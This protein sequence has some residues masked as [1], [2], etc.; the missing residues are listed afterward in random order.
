LKNIYTSCYN[1]KIFCGYIIYSRLTV[2]TLDHNVNTVLS[3]NNKKSNNELNIVEN[4]LKL[5]DS[6]L[7]VLK[8][9][10]AKDYMVVAKRKLKIQYLTHILV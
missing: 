10:Y 8:L 3:L 5:V 9:W 7:V 4:L 2:I 1:N 6:R